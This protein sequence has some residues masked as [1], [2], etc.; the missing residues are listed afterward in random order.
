MTKFYVYATDPDSILKGECNWGFETRTD[1]PAEHQK[2]CLGVLVA[3]IE[4]DIESK[5]DEIRAMALS[6]LQNK[7]KQVR[8]ASEVKTQEIKQKIA[9]LQA[10]PNLR[11]VS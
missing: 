9:E 2:Y 1:A 7:L 3:E 10:L 4:I 11:A 8:V 6:T 5:R